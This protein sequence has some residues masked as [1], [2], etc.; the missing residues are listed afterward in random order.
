[1][2]NCFSM[3]Y[4]HYLMV[5]RVFSTLSFLLYIMI[6]TRIDNRIDLVKNNRLDIGRYF[7]IIVADAP[8]AQQDRASGS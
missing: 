3:T 4:T 8:V 2:Y 5:F 6:N 1:M 7:I